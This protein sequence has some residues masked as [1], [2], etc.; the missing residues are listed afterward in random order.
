MLLLLMVAMVVVV[1]LMMLLAQPAD[2][3]RI[4][5]ERSLHHCAC[6][7]PPPREVP[8]H[9][10]GER[11]AR[12]DLMRNEKC[13]FIKGVLQ[14]RGLISCIVRS[15]SPRIVGVVFYCNVIIGVCT[16]DEPSNS[17]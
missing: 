8:P 11:R 5:G 13:C 15:F 2:L 12:P 4:R 3:A 1:V 16:G 9:P 7:A 10:G 17:S 14:V 6:V